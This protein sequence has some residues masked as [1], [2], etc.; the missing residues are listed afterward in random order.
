MGIRFDRERR[1]FTIETANTAYQMAA[2]SHDVLQHLYYG[3]RTGSDMSYMHRRCDRGFSGNIDGAEENRSYSLDTICQEYACAG[4][5]DY[6]VPALVVRNDDGST[7]ADLR[8]R[9][10]EIREGK[11]A[12]PGMP[13]VYDNGGEAQTLIISLED[14]VSGLAVQL[15]YGVFPDMDIITRAAQI[16]SGSRPVTLERAMSACVELPFGQWDLIHFHGRHCMERQF[17]RTPLPHAIQTVASRRGMT[18]HHHNPFVI[19]CDRHADEDH[20]DCL[21]MILVYSGDHRTEIERDQTDSVRAVMGIHD[22]TFSWELQPGE[23]FFTPEV[24]LTFS[25]KGLTRL[26]HNCHRIIRNNICRGRYKLARRPVLINNWEATYFDFNEDK[27]MGLARQA[28]D[29]GIEMFVL[30]DGWFGA[31]NNDRAGLGDWKV[32]L[33]KLP[34][35]L[36]GLAEQIHA[37]G[38]RFGLWIEPEMVN[39]DSDLYRA[40][41][42]WAFTVPG[43]GP[44][45]SR[46]QLVLDLSREDVR[47]YLYGAISAILRENAID[48]IKWDFNRAMEDVFSRALPAGRQGEVRHRYV[49]GL[50][51]LLDRLTSEF[52]QVLFEG[53]AGGGGRFDPAMLY[54]SPQIWCSDDT[55]AIE[56]LKIQYGTSFGYPVSAVG[57][58]VSASP[59][60]QTGRSTPLHTRAV[61]AMSGTFGYELDL[62]SLSEE[63]KEE[64]RGQ[65]AVY[66]KYADLIRSGDY[67]RL[68]ETDLDYTAWQFVA[69]DLSESLVNLVVT[70]PLANGP[71]IHVKLKGLDPRAVYEDEAS[72]DRFTGA[73]LMYGGYTFPVMTGDYPALQIHLVRVLFE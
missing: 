25:S 4:T 32:N 60:H 6:R 33:E 14:P 38:M 59:N 21:G 29:L 1:L 7:C 26:S 31:R 51:R 62:N 45:R 23:T 66:H 61:V 13:A 2:D 39:E 3:R 65:I 63:E 28:A 52:T 54:Y 57:S 9:G 24:I 18:S 34:S 20:G 72:G 8:Y 44:V 48:Y 16:R 27:I 10:Y 41:P 46:H 15:F 22:G 53:C 47:D 37:L 70:H 56:R 68:T 64:I 40:H 67:Y 5:G 49:L 42:D 43:R 11:Y 19:L 36:V 73:A 58:H 69:P 12:I 55:D 50:Y 71:F 30:D 17:E 35:G